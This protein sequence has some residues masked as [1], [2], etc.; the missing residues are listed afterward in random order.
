VPTDIMKSFAKSYLEVWRYRELFFFLAW[1]DVKIRYKQT[2]FGILWA[3]IQPVF[4]ML[5]FTVLF[6][7][8]G[9]MPSNGAPHPLFYLSALLPWI[10]FSATLPV[11]ANS[12]VSNTDLL[13]KV[14]FPRVI[15]PASATIGG[16]FDFFIGTLLLGGLLAYYRITPSAALLLW[17]FCVLLLVVLT[18]GIGMVLAALNVK[19]RDVKHAVPFGIQLFLF[20]TPV[21]YPV[22]LLP[23][24]FR[25]WI[26][27]N[28]LSGVIETFRASLLPSQ[29]IDWQLIGISSLATLLIFILGFVYFAR[30]ERAFADVV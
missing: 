19:Y 8:L 27:L 30:S 25:F 22:S 6:G 11:S 20:I 14:Y 17:P 13:T 5:V 29:A 28:P 16:L 15:L 2:F 3:I 9:Q 1:R 26:A 23:E 18:L 4:T 24:R 21:I 12:L 7:K 10:Y